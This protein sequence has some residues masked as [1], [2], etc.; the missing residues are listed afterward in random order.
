MKTAVYFI[1]TCCAIAV[2]NAYDIFYYADNL[3]EVPLD[4]ACYAI[5]EDVCCTVPAA[6]SVWFNCEPG[7][8]WWVYWGGE[9][10]YAYGGDEGPACFNS[11]S[12]C[13]TGA[14]YSGTVSTLRSRDAPLRNASTPAS[15]RKKTVKT[16]ADLKLNSRD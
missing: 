4:L 13:V 16:A 11:E 2:A 3:C 5:P 9:C 6:D 15:E 7:D 8:I 14:L 1:L 12:Q 10:T